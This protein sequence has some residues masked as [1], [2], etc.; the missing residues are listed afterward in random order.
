MA[1]LPEMKVYLQPLNDRAPKPV[2]DARQRPALVARG[3]AF[4][5]LPMR[6]P[7]KEFNGPAPASSVLRACQSAG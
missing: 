7:S 3:S 4:F 6:S 2:L 5:F 1:K